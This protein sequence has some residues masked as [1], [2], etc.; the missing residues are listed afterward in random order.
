MKKISHVSHT[1]DIQIKVDAD[2]LEELFE[3]ALEG[4]NNI[5]KSDIP[6]VNAAQNDRFEVSLTAPD[7]SCLLIDFLSEILTESH[8]KNKIFSGLKI[9]E[10][11]PS[12]IKAQVYGQTVKLF[13]EDV[14]AVTYHM[15]KVEQG[16]D[17]KWHTSIVFDI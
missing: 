7:T 4:M 5:L 16:P 8:E 12:F 14:K 2:T 17:G 1:A 6:S 15:A 9:L 13:D 3:G 10:L 11:N